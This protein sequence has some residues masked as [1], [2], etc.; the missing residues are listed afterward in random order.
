[1]NKLLKRKYLKK[2]YF[3][4]FLRLLTVLLAAG[5]KFY[6]KQAEVNDLRWILEPTVF[7]SGLFTGISFLFN[8]E[9]G[10]INP[11]QNIIIDEGCAGLNFLVIVITMA[12]FTLLT[13]NLNKELKKLQIFF[14]WIRLICISY[15]ATIIINASRITI[16]I[17]LKKI[18]KEVTDYGSRQH[19]IEGIFIYVSGLIAFYFL[20]EK[21]KHNTHLKL[22]I[23]E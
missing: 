14:L 23:K 19:M 18:L 1:M 6:Y 12:C 16:S 2:T 22:K 3:L 21:I 13:K 20:L 17:F 5:L 9:L 7:I 4:Y 15:G 10:Y 8:S 11:E